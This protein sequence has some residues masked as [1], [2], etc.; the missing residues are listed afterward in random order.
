[1]SFLAEKHIIKFAVL[2]DFGMYIMATPLS[3][4]RP[5]NQHLLN[6]TTVHSTRHHPC[7]LLNHIQK[8]APSVQTP[9]SQ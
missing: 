4:H 5:H 7:N 2:S 8:S 1:M 6:Q 9:Q 3:R